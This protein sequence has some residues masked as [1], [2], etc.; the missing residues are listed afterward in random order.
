[1]LLSGEA[2]PEAGGLAN[3]ANE[4]GIDKNTLMG[5]YLPL[6]GLQYRVDMW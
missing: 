1:M 4:G 2:H 3:K 6:M 5:R